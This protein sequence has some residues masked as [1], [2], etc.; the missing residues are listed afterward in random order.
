MKS[1][2]YNISFV[3]DYLEVHTVQNWLNICRSP[4]IQEFWKNMTGTEFSSEELDGFGVLFGIQ[5]QW[6]ID[7][8]ADFSSFYDQNSAHIL[9]EFVV[10]CFFGFVLLFFNSLTVLTEKVDKNWN[11]QLCEEQNSD[12][13][14]SW[15]QLILARHYCAIKKCVRKF[16]D[17]L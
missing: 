12:Q 2:N 10:H 15:S 6:K 3:F 4:L 17:P 9:E 1:C 11:F 7:L 5:I 14:S 13:R 16:I 8:I